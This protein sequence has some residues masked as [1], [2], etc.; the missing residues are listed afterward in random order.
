MKTGCSATAAR[1]FDLPKLSVQFFL[2][3]CS[4]GGAMQHHQ[5]GLSRKAHE[6]M[7]SRYV[8]NCHSPSSSY[9]EIVFHETWLTVR[10]PE[11][12]VSLSNIHMNSPSFPREDDVDS[13]IYHRTRK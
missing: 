3:F 9:K 12:F 7:R 6:V 2:L 10:T 11:V 8:C 4:C 5:V 1:N 13:Q